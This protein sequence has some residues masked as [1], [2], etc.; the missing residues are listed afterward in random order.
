MT[1]TPS[2]AS[3]GNPLPVRIFVWGRGVRTRRKERKK[4]KKRRK[5]RKRILCVNGDLITVT[6]MI[7]RMIAIFSLVH[8][9]L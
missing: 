7:A 9:T 3:A 2:L 4:R 5:R 1:A 6:A 8:G